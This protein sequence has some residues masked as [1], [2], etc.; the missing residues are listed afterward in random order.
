MN[1]LPKDLHDIIYKNKY[2]LDFSECIKEINNIEYETHVDWEEYTFSTRKY[3]NKVT[4]MCL[5]C[6]FH[7]RCAIGIDFHISNEKGTTYIGREKTFSEDR[8]YILTS[9]NI[10]I[11]FTSTEEEEELEKKF[12]KYFDEQMAEEKAERMVEEYDTGS[13]EESEV[14]EIIKDTEYDTI[15]NEKRSNIMN[16]NKFKKRKEKLKNIKKKKNKNKRNKYKNI[17]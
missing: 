17:L 14:Y 3:K 4:E 7:I 1:N 13:E 10:H 2:Q 6:P 15:K 12:K 5:T 9:E 8:S 11:T 16:K